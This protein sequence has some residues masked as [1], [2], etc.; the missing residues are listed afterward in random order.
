M[1]MDTT[2]MYITLNVVTM[3][4]TTRVYTRMVHVTDMM[5]PH[6][7]SSIDFG[8]CSITPLSYKISLYCCDVVASPAGVLVG[9]LLSPALVHGSDDD[10][11][12]TKFQTLVCIHLILL[13]VHQCIV[14]LAMLA[15]KL[16]NLVCTFILWA[17]DVT[18]GNNGSTQMYCW[19]L[20]L[21]YVVF[22]P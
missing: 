10:D 18:S 8:S 14:M 3:T 12:S 17:A 9:N 1:G 5:N 16:S 7:L 6:W 2:S 11:L 22:D 21:C 19:R 13:L 20:L 15:S 4:V